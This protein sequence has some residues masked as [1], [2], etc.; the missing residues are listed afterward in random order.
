LHTLTLTRDPDWREGPLVQIS[1]GKQAIIQGNARGV[2]VRELKIE[3]KALLGQLI[4]RIGQLKHLKG[5][6]L[7]NLQK[8]FER[9]AKRLWPKRKILPTLYSL[10]HQLGSDI[11]ASGLSD[12]ERAAIM[13]HL[14]QSSIESYG[15]VQSGK[16]RAIKATQATVSQVKSDPPRSRTLHNRIP[17][18]KEAGGKGSRM[19]L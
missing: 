12:A 4:Y 1:G 17:P 14:S 11:K 19:K 7:N 9:A 15:Y 8:R 3:D 13:G 10:R 18:G 16:R 2:P 5:K 6:R